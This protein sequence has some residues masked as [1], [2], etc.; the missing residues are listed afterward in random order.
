MEA[1][2]PLGTDESALVSALREGDEDAFIALV[3]TH[4]PAMVRLAQHYVSS[5]AVAEEVVQDSWIGVLKG[6]P[7]FE[8]RS[9]LRSWIFQIVINQAKT[10]GQREAR[11]VPTR[12]L[13]EDEDGPS[14]DPDRFFPDGH[15]T[16]GGRWLHPVSNWRVPHLEARASELREVIDR[17]I[18][19]LPEKQA[20]VVRLRDGFGFSSAEV[21]DTLM[22]SE[23]N[24]RVLLHRARSR[25]RQRLEDFLK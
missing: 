17:E 11:S 8:G 15:P 4:H 9:S 1:P 22:I 13:A 16:Q 5:R 3:E 18:S 12:S 25:L 7:G 2:G 10:R 24:Q 20:A 23:A 6:L 21:C 19:L 14:V